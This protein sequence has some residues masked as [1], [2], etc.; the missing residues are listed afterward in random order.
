MLV[1]DLPF[2]IHRGAFR[3]LGRNKEIEA[4]NKNIV[5][6]IIEPLNPLH[7]FGI[8][9]MGRPLR[10]DFDKMA[11]KNQMARELEELREALEREKR[12]KRGL[13]AA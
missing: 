6:N 9:A 1:C 3:T 2:C 13:E 11:P 4:F 10:E 7:Q 8:R 5:I 12:E